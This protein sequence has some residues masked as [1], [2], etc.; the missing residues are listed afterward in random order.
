LRPWGRQRRTAASDA[1]SA[2]PGA[3]SCVRPHMRAA[4]GDGRSTPALPRSA[5]LRCSLCAEKRECGGVGLSVL[6]AVAVNTADAAVVQGRPRLSRCAWGADGPCLCSSPISV[7]SSRSPPPT[8]S[9]RWPRACT[10]APAPSR[11]RASRPPAHTDGASLRCRLMQGAP[12]GAGGNSNSSYGDGE[13]WDSGSEVSAGART[14]PRRMRPRPLLAASTNTDFCLPQSAATQTAIN[15][16]TWRPLTPG[17]LPL[18]PR[19]L[20]PRRGNTLA[21]AP[22]HARTPARCPPSCA[23][24]PRSRT[25][26]RTCPRTSTTPTTKSPARQALGRA[27]GARLRFSLEEL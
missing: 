9:T 10:L 19:T 27:Q 21:L 5:G 14:T 24:P 6:H 1:A 16:G 12:F 8:C 2:M 13:S 15:P 22:W 26:A 4:A 17:S 23:L 3:A 20:S 18:V 11:P 7:P 25:R